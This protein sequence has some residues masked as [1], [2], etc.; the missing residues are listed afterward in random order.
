[1]QQKELMRLAL[2]KAILSPDCL[3]L[4]PY[5]RP[6]EV[7]ALHEED[8]R[9]QMGEWLPGQMS[10]SAFLWDIVLIARGREAI[11]FTRRNQLP[12]CSL[13]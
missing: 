11:G 6:L 2:Y 9:C 1:M 12:K 5:G 10:E 4:G 8:A 13:D 7:R 3:K